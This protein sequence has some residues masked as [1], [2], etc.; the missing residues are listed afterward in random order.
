MLPV[1]W[2]AYRIDAVLGGDKGLGDDLRLS[3]SQGAEA[4][5]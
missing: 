5:A 2:A 3:L 4:L 1:V